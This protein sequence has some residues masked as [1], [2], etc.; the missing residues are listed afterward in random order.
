MKAC[1][2]SVRNNDVFSLDVP[3]WKDES[4]GLI[5]IFNQDLKWEPDSRFSGL[6]R[7]HQ[8]IP[9]NNLS[10]I[11]SM[12]EGSTPLIS[13]DW[14]GMNILVKMD[15]LFPTGSYKD[16]GATVMISK[17]KEWGLTEVVEDSSGNAGSAIAAYCAMAGIKCHIFAPASAP[18]S[19]LKAIKVFGAH[20]ITV[21]G[22]RE[23]A[24]TAAL[25]M[26][27]DCFYASHVWNPFFMEGTKTCAFEIAEQLNFN[28]PD[29]IAMPVGNG[30]LLLGIY[31][32]FKE[33]RELKLIDKIPE[34]MAF[35]AA[36]CNPI[37]Q[38]FNQQEVIVSRFKPSLAD[39]ISN[40]EPARKQQIIHAV[41]ESK[42]IILSLEE[43]EIQ[44]A[45]K[46]LLS[47]GLLLEPT[48]VVTFAGLAKFKSEFENRKTVVIATGHG[49][50]AID[51]IPV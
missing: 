19:K 6:W 25:E 32:G 33:L 4:G 50:K 9:L 48:S 3:R 11:V 38:S 43:D 41:K 14:Q 45:W 2:V 13:L 47:K 1:F 17:I 26:T 22:T 44:Q 36:N 16:R 10:N 30:S 29:C 42:G 8:M 51:R 20:L 21:E 31:N 39:G 46:Q 28:M 34:I 37:E 49:L 15:Q 24:T 5:D 12:G 7:Y 27:N 40:A 18:A 23:A 35:Q